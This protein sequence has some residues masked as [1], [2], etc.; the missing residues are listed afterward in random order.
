MEKA[1]LNREIGMC[2]LMPST[3]M[4]I[5]GNPIYEPFGPCAE[6]QPIPRANVTLIRSITFHE[7]SSDCLI[8]CCIVTLLNFGICSILIAYSSVLRKMRIKQK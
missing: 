1:E 5:S 3:P 6:L 7:I 2:A 8:D 4:S